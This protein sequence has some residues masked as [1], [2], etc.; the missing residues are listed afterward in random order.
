MEQSDGVLR[1]TRGK[2]SPF[3][4]KEA[5]KL[6]ESIRSMSA[7]E[8]EAELD[9][10]DERYGGN[11]RAELKRLKA[12]VRRLPESAAQ[13]TEPQWRSGTALSTL[14]SSGVWG[15]GGR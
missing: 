13:G 12:F 11:H 3:L 7:T 10:H 5:K 15:E 6:A 14:A 4:D 1:M 9:R 8:V 2:Q